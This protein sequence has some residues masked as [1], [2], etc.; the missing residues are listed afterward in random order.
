MNNNVFVL[1]DDPERIEQFKERFVEQNLIGYFATNVE[2]A[3]KIVSSIECSY[4]FLD[5]DLGNQ[6]FVDQ[7]EEDTGSG[8]VRWC[9]E[10]VSVFKNVNGIFIHSLNEP[11]AKSMHLTLDDYRR[12][13]DR[14]MLPHTIRYPFCWTKKSFPIKVK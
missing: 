7:K 11:A 13:A 14:N 5:H 9:C 3:K 8:F 1:E 6:I 2:E 4:W 10:N 12:K